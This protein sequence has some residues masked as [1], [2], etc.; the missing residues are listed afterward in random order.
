M[1]TPSPVQLDNAMVTIIEAAMRA[2]SSHNTQ[3]WRFR[4]DDFG[5]HLYADRT[6]ALPV[7]DPFDRELTMSCACVLFHIRVA[8][9]AQGIASDVFVLP[10]PADPDHL[11]T[12]KLHRG[13]YSVT[14]ASLIAAI[15]AR[16]TYR[17]AFE[18]QQIPEATLDKLCAAAAQEGAWLAILSGEQVRHDTAALVAEGD[19]IHWANPSWRRE[20]A[21]WMHPRRQGDGLTIPWLAAPFA[22]MIVRTFDRGDGIGAKDRQIADDSPLLAVLGTT[23]DETEDWMSAGQALARVLLLAAHH[24]IQ[25]SFLNQPVQI[26]ELR[27]KLQ[28]LV[29]HP[30]YPQIVLRMGYVAGKLP[31]TPR[32]PL[33]EV[34][35]AH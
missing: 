32:R 16:H 22:Q 23:A 11:A 19:A 33:H 28:S 3:P 25:A 10:N 9:A 12:V 8:A 4:V 2:P 30:G 34:V 35:D 5:V 24:D 17:K 21:A 18:P 15:A 6:R 1:T 20:L 29:G 26:S 13:D 31:I 27:P 7:N 14:D